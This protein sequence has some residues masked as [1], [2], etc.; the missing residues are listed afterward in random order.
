LTILK[1][2]GRDS[3]DGDGENV[4]FPM[5]DLGKVSVR[6]GFYNPSSILL[7]TVDIPLRFHSH[8]QCIVKRCRWFNSHG[9]G[10]ANDVASRDNLENTKNTKWRRFGPRD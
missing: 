8:S 3:D 4:G 7:L 9:Q 5:F 10:A 2:K 6:Y 1:L